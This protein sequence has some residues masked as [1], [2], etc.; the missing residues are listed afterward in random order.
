VDLIRRILTGSSPES[1][2]SNKKMRTAIKHICDSSF[3]ERLL[4]E[5]EIARCNPGLALKT[6]LE[7]GAHSNE[8]K[9]RTDNS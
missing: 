6:H 8:Y 7:K 3:N 2:L 9:Q 1:A 5:Q 4:T